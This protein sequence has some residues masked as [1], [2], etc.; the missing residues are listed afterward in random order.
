[1]RHD[2]VGFRAIDF[3]KLIMLTI[4]RLAI[5]SLLV[6]SGVSGQSVQVAD[7]IWAAK[8][9]PINGHTY[10]VTG[11]GQQRAEVV[12][13]NA[14]G[15]VV[16][17]T[18][19]PS[20]PTPPNGSCGATVAYTSVAL[21]AGADQTF[22]IAAS[23]S[24]EPF[25]D[26]NDMWIGSLDSPASARLGG[27]GGIQT[28]V[29][30]VNG[31]VFGTA[32]SGG[33]RFQR[34]VNH[35]TGEQLPGGTADMR[36]VFARNGVIGFGATARGGSP[37]LL[38][39][40]GQVVTDPLPG[41]PGALQ[42]IR[43]SSVAGSF[44]AF[45]AR[46]GLGDPLRTYMLDGVTGTVYSFDAPDINVRAV[47]ETGWIFGD[48]WAANPFLYGSRILSAKDLCTAQGLSCDWAISTIGFSEFLDARSGQMFA[49]V[50]FT[51][52]YSAGAL[53]RAIYSPSTVPEPS[54]LVLFAAGALALQLNARRRHKTAAQV[55]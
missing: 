7:R 3:R 2:D 26:R 5:L 37:T 39:I 30:V 36:T 54:S 18:L 23:N 35:S 25:L 20:I 38:V 48:G 8:T 17:R 51:N 28:A 27:A 22:G 16:S 31:N 4:E 6:A 42:E 40:G 1:M 49:T 21:G 44:H 46:T 32:T 9:N 50:A 41:F 19:L 10:Y 52:G 14:A 29:G 45:V 43:A 24:C 11:A 13:V 53:G 15:A 34:P 47:S 12:Q 33:P 55:E